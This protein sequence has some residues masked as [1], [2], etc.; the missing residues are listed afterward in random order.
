MTLLEKIF[1][2]IILIICDLY[3]NLLD[4]SIFL[5]HN[6]LWSCYLN[7]Y[8]I[9]VWLGILI[10]PI[11]IL[12]FLCKC[13]LCVIDIII[14]YQY[15][16]NMLLYIFFNTDTLKNFEDVLKK[17]WNVKKLKIIK[18]IIQYI[19]KLCKLLWNYYTFFVW[20]LIHLVYGIS[21]FYYT[22]NM[23][24]LFYIITYIL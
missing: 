22:I 21:D 16:N 20:G 2:E 15:R 12:Y 6:S 1:N 4:T 9:G 13:V 14:N 3:P 24:R 17:F 19:I 18:I 8:N 23:V 10:I 7:I 5:E 11:Y